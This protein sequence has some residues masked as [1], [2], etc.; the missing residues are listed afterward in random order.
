[1]VLWLIMWP[2]CPALGLQLTNPAHEPQRPSSSALASDVTNQHHC[3]LFTWVRGSEI[4]SSDLVES[5]YPIEPAR[6][7]FRL[8]SVVKGD[9]DLS[10]KHRGDWGL[11]LECHSCEI[12]FEDAQ[13]Y[14]SAQRHSVFQDSL[15]SQRNNSRKGRLQ[16]CIVP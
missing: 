2:P 8:D 11:G 12:P 16:E 10:L 13:L 9:V 4:R 5:T 1:M 6:W 14:W 7:P 15:S 3:L